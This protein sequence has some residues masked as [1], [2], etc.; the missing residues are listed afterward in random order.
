MG[1]GTQDVKNNEKEIHC[2][3]VMENEK[4]RNKKIL[5]QDLAKEIDRPIASGGSMDCFMDSE[6]H[7]D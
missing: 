3:G 6:M 1:Y 2:D 4:L 5:V 7:G